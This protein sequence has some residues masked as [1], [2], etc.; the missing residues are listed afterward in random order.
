MREVLG[1]R[2]LS[3]DPCGFLEQA[4]IAAAEQDDGCDA[5]KAIPLGQWLR[6][7]G[8]VP[9]RSAKTHLSRLATYA[10]ETGECIR[11]VRNG[12]PWIEIRPLAQSGRRR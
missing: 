1:S 10:N 4:L 9:M 3:E 5:R 11:V 8:G 12:M 6:D 7:D 2:A